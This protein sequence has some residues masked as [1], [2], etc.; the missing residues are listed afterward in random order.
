ME[1]IKQLNPNGDPFSVN[2]SPEDRIRCHNG[3]VAGS[4]AAGRKRP[5]VRP[6]IAP[7]NPSPAG[8]RDLTDRLSIRAKRGRN[9]RLRGSAARRGRCV[10]RQGEE[11]KGVPTKSCPEKDA[12]SAAGSERSGAVLLR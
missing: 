4:L 7:L 8:R 5:Y 9:V 6:P 12:G 1:R 2:H 3:A 10:G 11:A